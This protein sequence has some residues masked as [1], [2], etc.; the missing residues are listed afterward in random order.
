[1]TPKTAGRPNERCQIDISVKRSY[2]ITLQACRKRSAVW[3][4]TQFTHCYH[5]VHSIVDLCRRV[6][7]VYIYIFLKSEHDCSIRRF[8]LIVY[9]SNVRVRKKENLVVL[10]PTTLHTRGLCKYVSETSVFVTRHF[11]QH[12]TYNIYPCE[13]FIRD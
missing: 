9:S 12:I 4:L 6:V 13:Y 2:V 8:S 7:I 1:V 3:E 5:T 10:R 11:A